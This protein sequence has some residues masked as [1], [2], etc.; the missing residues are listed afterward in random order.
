MFLGVHVKGFE[1]FSQAVANYISTR[2]DPHLLF[3]SKIPG[4]LD[5]KWLLSVKQLGICIAA[6]VETLKDLDQ[7]DRIGVIHS[8]RLVVRGPIRSSATQN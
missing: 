3:S 1:L 2:Y 8:H 7:T 4:P 6:I 5:R